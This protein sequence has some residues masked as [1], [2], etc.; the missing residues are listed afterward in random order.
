MEALKLDHF[1]LYGAGNYGVYAAADYARHHSEHVSA[2]LL[3]AVVLSADSIKAPGLWER[4]LDQDWVTFLH[5]ILP[6]DIDLEERNRLMELQLQA[7]DQEN[8]S[9]LMNAFMQEKAPHPLLGLSSRVP[10]LVMHPRDFSIMGAEEAAK[11][12]QK[13]HAQMTLIE[14]SYTTGTADSGL[15]AIDA[16]L[17]TT[18]AGQSP[19]G[20]VTTDARFSAREVEVLRLIAAGKSNQQIADELVLSVNTVARHVANILDKAGV[21]N[22]TEAAAYGREKGLL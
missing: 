17:A 13:G 10:T 9:I 7:F 14:G 21:A 20:S 6:R 4:V 11:V 3:C 12:A 5:S 19:A 18:A 16:F 15:A 22:R 2:L 1:I 8:F